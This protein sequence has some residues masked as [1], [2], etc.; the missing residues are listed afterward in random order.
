MSIAILEND[1]PAGTLAGM[2]TGA[3]IRA[4]RALLNWSR[5]DLARV[6][7][8]SANAIANIEMGASRPLAITLDSIQRSLEKSGVA[9]TN[10]DEPGVKL[11]KV[12][13]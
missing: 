3:Q 11:K 5:G 13:P 10:G 2:I 12:A 7:G 4:A 6:S 9:F 1:W 8:V